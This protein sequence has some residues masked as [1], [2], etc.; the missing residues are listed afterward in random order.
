M[1]GRGQASLRPRRP[2]SRAVEEESRVCSSRVRPHLVDFLLGRGGGAGGGPSIGP[3]EPVLRDALDLGLLGH[4]LADPHAVG[5]LLGDVH[6]GAVVAT[7]RQYARPEATASGSPASV[8]GERAWNVGCVAREGRDGWR[9][10]SREGRARGGAEETT[11]E[12][13]GCFA[14]RSSMSPRGLDGRGASD[15][16]TASEAAMALGEWR[17][18]SRR[19]ARRASA[20]EEGWDGSVVERTAREVETPCVTPGSRG[21][22]HRTARAPDARTLYRGS[23]TRAS[24]RRWRVARGFLMTGSVAVVLLA[25]FM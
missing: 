9:R 15:A 12:T 7:P 22:S 5:V 1:T 23:R 4:D 8:V 21:A 16:A 14:T 13:P 3:A 11:D 19:E 6:R 25:L 2:V 18:R 10:T 17:E 24:E 20:E